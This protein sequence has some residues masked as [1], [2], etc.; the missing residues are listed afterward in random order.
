[1]VYSELMEVMHSFRL[2]ELTKEDMNYAWCLWQMG[3][4]RD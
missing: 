3:G 4:C 2:G 1:M